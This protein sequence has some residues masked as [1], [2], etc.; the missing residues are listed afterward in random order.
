MSELK[1]CPFCGGE[2]LLLL[3]S[4]DFGDDKVGIGC[5]TC[6]AGLSVYAGDIDAGREYEVVEEFD[7]NGFAADTQLFKPLIDKWNR[8]DGNW[9][10]CSE[11]NPPNRKRVLLRVVAFSLEE[12]IGFYDK[13]YPMRPW[14]IQT[15]NLLPSE[16]THWQPLPEPPK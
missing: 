14:R 10:A 9:I 16:V 2:P 1:S 6:D 7:K 4:D 5:K 3:H 15:R 12:Q 13:S 11:R 8:R